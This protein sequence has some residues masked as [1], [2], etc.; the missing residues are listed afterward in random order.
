MAFRFSKTGKTHYIWK[1]IDTYWVCS[2]NYYFTNFIVSQRLIALKC[3]SPEVDFIAVTVQFNFVYAIEEHIAYMCCTC[4]VVVRCSNMRW[5]N[6]NRECISKELLL[7]TSL[8]Y[9]IHC[10][11]TDISGF[12]YHPKLKPHLNLFHSLVQLHRHIF[13]FQCCRCRSFNKWF[14]CKIYG[15]GDTL[16]CN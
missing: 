2:C 1:A 14:L 13:D 5:K 12:H 15:S 8:V 4:S 6:S 3:T 7:F 16:L 11:R 9:S 10:I